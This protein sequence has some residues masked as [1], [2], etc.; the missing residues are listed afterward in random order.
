MHVWA[1]EPRLGGIYVLCVDGEP[2]ASTSLVDRNL[3]R[4]EQI[5]ALAQAAWPPPQ[6]LTAVYE[7]IVQGKQP[8]P[9]L[10]TL[11]GDRRISP[12]LG[13][14]AA[15][16][17]GDDCPSEHPV[18]RYLFPDLERSGALALDPSERIITTW[19]SF[20][21]ELTAQSSSEGTTTGT[22]TYVPSGELRGWQCVLTNQRVVYHGRLAVPLAV[23]EDYPS[24]FVPGPLFEAIAGFR[25]VKRWTTRP[26]LHWGFHIRHEWVSELGYGNFPDRKRPLLVRRDDTLFLFAGFRYPSGET[27]IF[28][29]PYKQAEPAVG[30]IADAYVRAVRDAQ[31]QAIVSEPVKAARQVQAPSLFSFKKETEATTTWTI[32]GA[33]PWSL[34]PVL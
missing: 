15:T 34:P 9:F 8:T 27:A 4:A 31:P 28:R 3:S 17:D 19:K 22:G 24:I 33:V 18:R 32:E 23:R 30:D 26:N 10:G 11:P 13:G 20:V 16:I 29:L 25:Q 21:P 6:Q 1:Q 14:F 5:N 7:A 12:L 2:V